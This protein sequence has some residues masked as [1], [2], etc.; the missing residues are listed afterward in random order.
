MGAPR[1]TSARHTWCLE[2][3]ATPHE[4]IEE[5]T[6]FA[7]GA[8]ELDSVEARGTG[9]DGEDGEKGQLVNNIIR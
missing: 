5:K 6:F 2:Q 1:P 4:L 7:L 8:L 9:Q 3:L